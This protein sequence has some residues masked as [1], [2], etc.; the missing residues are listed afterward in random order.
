MRLPFDS[1]VIARAPSLL[2]PAILFP[3]YV[4]PT[5]IWQRVAS[6]YAFVAC[7]WIGRLP[8]IDDPRQCSNTRHGTN[9]APVQDL[10]MQTDPKGLHTG[11]SR[12]TVRSILPCCMQVKKAELQDPCRQ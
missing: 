11:L 5:M 9:R 10:A 3:R 12:Y 1:I 7:T 2:L 4:L 6:L 8:E